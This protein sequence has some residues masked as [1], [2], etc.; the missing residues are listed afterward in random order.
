MKI[1]TGGKWPEVDLAPQVILNCDLIDNGCHGGDPITAYQFIHEQGG[2]PDE[3][4]QLYTATGHDT[5]NTCTA[6]DVC[7]NC[8]PGTGCFAQ[9]TYK[10]YGISEYGLVNGTANMMNEIA[11]RGPIAC[12]VAVT[13][14]FLAYKGGIFEDKTGDVSMDHSISVVGYGSENGVD[15]WIG[16]NRFGVLLLTLLYQS[17]PSPLIL[18]NVNQ[19]IY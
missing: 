14:E 13:P 5:G 4:C 17:F 16:R 15:F 9:K 3:T 19:L 8:S 1:A 11:S 7:R 18:A 6:M 12:T 10:K 2:I